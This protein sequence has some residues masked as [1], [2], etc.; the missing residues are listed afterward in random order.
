V[1]VRKEL[2]IG[3]RWLPA[4]AEDNIE[5]VS[6]HTERAIAEVPDGSPQDVDRAVAAARAAQGG[7]WGRDAR[8]RAAALRRL[9][10]Q[11][12]KRADE[13]AA[14]V[15]EEIGAPS[16]DAR[17]VHVDYAETMVEYYASLA[18]ATEAVETRALGAERSVVRRLPLG[19]VG[20]IVPWNGPLL[21]PLLKLAPAL[22]AGCSVVLKPAPEATMTAF[23]LAEA[24][25]A[26][27]LPAGVLNVVAGGRQ[28]GEFLV[29]HAGVDKVSFTGSTTAGRRIGA[30][31]GER[32]RPVTLELGGKSA[33]IIL[34][35]AD[36]EATAKALLPNM[37][38][39]CGQVCV[40][41]SRVLV[42]ERRYR[43]YLDAIADVAKSIVVGDP[44]DPVTQM[45]P[46]VA[47]R[48]RSRVENYVRIGQ[49]EGARVVTGGKRPRTP[50]TGWYFEPTVFAGVHQSMRVAREEIFG[51]VVAV[52][53]YRDEDE[54]V[55]TANDTDYG[56]A[57]SI[58]TADVERGVELS[59]RIA[60]GI[61]AINSFG[62]RLAAPFG[63]TKS[64]GLG[65]E[66]GPEGMYAYTRLQSVS[67]PSD[68]L[69][70]QAGRE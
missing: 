45:G 11:I 40:A 34:D 23:L 67:L 12:V 65:Y 47:E 53:P 16:A 6:P 37:F 28:T 36:V 5:L 50:K 30:L 33:A 21:S 38:G 15:T 7:D 63:G 1:H 10:E 26:A 42:P 14:T 70:D 44:H 2:Y 4:A 54:A 69:G 35:D 59:R 62:G 19:V 39:N 13:I 58:W 27:D 64:S 31:C 18:P 61:V 52:M 68:R 56:L 49:D 57:G 43:E 9:A 55:R 29:T 8:A 48:Q 46:L 32:M 24:A 25:D 20:A 17:A 60:S 22:A 66:M 3:G 41:D 51:P